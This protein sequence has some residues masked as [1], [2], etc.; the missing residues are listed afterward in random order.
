METLP[1]SAATGNP[2][3]FAPV[4]SW[5][6]H[7]LENLPDRDMAAFEFFESIRKGNCRGKV[8]EIRA[9]FA[10]AL[11]RTNGD[12]ETAKK[13][14]ATQKKRLPCVTLSGVF[15]MRAKDKL[16]THSG[17]LQADIDLLADR[18]AVIREALEG[19][20]HVASRGRSKSLIKPTIS[21]LLEAFLAFSNA[22]TTSGSLPVGA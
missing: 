20:P 5:F 7:S 16:Q 2:A 18:K 8:E 13:A 21:P 1:H 12:R 3:E 19:D 10:R 17:L 11:A 14:V 4:V 9:R 6:P 15:S 22:S